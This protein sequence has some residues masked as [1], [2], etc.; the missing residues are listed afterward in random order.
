MPAG[1]PLHGTATHRTTQHSHDERGNAV[2]MARLGFGVVKPEIRD[3]LSKA[4]DDTIRRLGGNHPPVSPTST[5]DMAAE[6]GRKK[7][8]YPIFEMTSAEQFLVNRSAEM[9]DQRSLT[10]PSHHTAS[11]WPSHGGGADLQEQPFAVGTRVVHESRGAGTVT[12]LMA[13][14]RTR[15][16]FDSGEEHRYR[17][18]SMHKLRAKTAPTRSG[19]AWCSPAGAA[20]GRNARLWPAASVGAPVFDA[21][22]VC[23]GWELAEEAPGA[24]LAHVSPPQHE[25]TQQLSEIAL[26]D[27]ATAFLQEM[28]QRLKTIRGRRAISSG[29]P[30]PGPVQ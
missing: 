4:E 3:M 24:R 27:T 18:S 28:I 19:R 13:D 22:G 23:C 20:A 12:D 5:M 7:E 15:V 14:G 11:V 26:N 2:M 8:A 6:A 1:K 29:Y 9:D 21:S 16:A 30:Q 10:E 17:P 25:T